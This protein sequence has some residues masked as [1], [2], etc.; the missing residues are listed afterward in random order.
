MIERFDLVFRCFNMGMWDWD[1][2]MGEMIF[3]D[4]W[5]IMFG[6]VLNEIFLIWE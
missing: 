4:I 2:K 6:Y 3:N 5:Y 1:I